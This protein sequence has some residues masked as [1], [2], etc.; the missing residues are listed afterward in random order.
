MKSLNDFNVYQI[1]ILQNILITY[2]SKNKFTPTIFQEEFIYGTCN[3]D[4]LNAPHHLQSFSL[5]QGWMK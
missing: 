3:S 2:K 1:N 4:T 5:V